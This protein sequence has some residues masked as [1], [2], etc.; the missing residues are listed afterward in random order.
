MSAQLGEGEAG[1]GEVA[2]GPL[3]ERRPDGAPRLAVGI[4]CGGQ[5]LARPHT[6]S[7]RRGVLRE[8]GGINAAQM[9]GGPSRSAPGGA[10]LC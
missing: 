1:R 4:E 8:D 9:R 5:P 2:H 6:Q 7:Q 10:W 3:V